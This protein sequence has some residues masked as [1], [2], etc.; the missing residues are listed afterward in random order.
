MFTLEFDDKLHVAYLFVF[1]ISPFL[2]CIYNMHWLQFQIQILIFYAYILK[3]LVDIPVLHRYTN[4][5]YYILKQFKYATLDSMPVSSRRPYN[6]RHWQWNRQVRSIGL[7]SMQKSKRFG[8]RLPWH[9]ENS[10]VTQNLKVTELHKI[11]LWANKSCV[12]PMRFQELK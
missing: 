8:L 5:K 6:Y 4:F 10:R 2:S 11:T 9:R 12:T 3:A 7:Y 1:S